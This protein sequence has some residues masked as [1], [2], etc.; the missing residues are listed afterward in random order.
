M[1]SFHGVVQANVYHFKWFICVWHYIKIKTKQKKTFLFQFE[2]KNV[3]ATTCLKHLAWIL[4]CWW[5]FYIDNLYC[6]P[7][8]VFVVFYCISALLPMLPR[9]LKTPFVFFLFNHLPTTI[10]IRTTNL[11]LYKFIYIVL[12]YTF[13]GVKTKR[14]CSFVGSS[15]IYRDG[16]GMRCLLHV[17]ALEKIW[18]IISLTKRWEKTTSRVEE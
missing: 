3:C 17:T 4:V 18:K 15:N 16:D 7:S 6:I 14:Q 11:L 5:K 2:Q 1:L 12:F 13:L 9:T 10:F 8:G